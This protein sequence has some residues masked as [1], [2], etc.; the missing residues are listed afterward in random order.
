MRLKH[1]EQGIHLLHTSKYQPHAIDIYWAIEKTTG[2]DTPSCKAIEEGGDG[3]K[4]QKKKKKEIL[5]QKTV[6]WPDLFV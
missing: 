3:R 1:L 6:K 4:V 2:V 5:T